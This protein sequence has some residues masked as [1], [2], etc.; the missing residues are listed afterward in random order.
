VRIYDY[1]RNCC[2]QG[3]HTYVE[4]C[5]AVSRVSCVGA[6]QGFREGLEV[7]LELNVAYE[8]E[9]KGRLYLA[10]FHEHDLCMAYAWKRVMKQF[11]APTEYEKL[12]LREYCTK[13]MCDEQL[14][15]LEIFMNRPFTF[16]NG[17]AG[18]GKSAFMRMLIEA[19]ASAQTDLAGDPFGLR[20]FQRQWMSFEDRSVTQIPTILFTTSM[21][22]NA[23]DLNKF[24]GGLA[25][26]NHALLQVRT[27]VPAV[28]DSSL[29]YRCT[30]PVATGQRQASSEQ[31]IT[32][33]R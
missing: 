28:Y 24:A 9:Q 12:T 16:V 26:T 13:E 22:H 25:M 2:F 20:I 5:Q 7:L 4:T 17:R 3:K 30:R 6:E 21:G 11:K 27:C 15:A 23:G 1:L 31:E 19:A 32:H 14:L 29:S 18:S 10:D 8:D 33:P